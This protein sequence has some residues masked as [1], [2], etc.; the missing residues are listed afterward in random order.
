M[1]TS[2]SARHADQ[3]S[4]VHLSHL[5][6]GVLQLREHLRS[7]L[8]DDSPQTEMIVYTRLY[9]LY[10]DFYLPFFVAKSH[11]PSRS[12]PGA[13]SAPSLGARPAA[14]AEARFI[15]A[16]YTQDVLAACVYLLDPASLPA[17]YIV[18]LT[19][20]AC[21]EAHNEANAS[22]VYISAAQR[23]FCGRVFVYTCWSSAALPL[24]MVLQALYPLLDPGV[25]GTPPATATTLLTPTSPPRERQGPSL[26]ENHI[27][28]DL[29][30]QERFASRKRLLRDT[31]TGLVLT[32]ANGVRALFRVLLLND[33]VTP[34]MTGEAAQLLVQL[35]TSPV[36]TLWQQQQQ[37]QQQLGET[38][39]HRSPF[40]G[41]GEE[42]CAAEV[43]VTHVTTALSV[44]DQ[45]RLLAPQLLALLEEH[46]DATSA[47]SSE[48]CTA[49]RPRFL[50]RL[51]AAR[52]RLP[53]ETLEQ[54][55][56]LATAML[57]NALT[58]LPPRD[59]HDF[60]RS[61]RQFFY[62]NK[63]VLSPGF[64]CLSLRSDTDV[65][66][67]DAIAALLRLRSLIKGVSSG[68][69]S[70]VMAHLLPATAAG[71][72]SIC[73]VLASSGDGDDNAAQFVSPSLP[74]ALRSLFTE[75]LSNPS[76]YDLCARAL[77]N[78]CGKAHAH[79]YLPGNAAQPR[80]RYTRDVCGRERLVTGLQWLLLD[81]AATTPGFVH[82]CVDVMVEAC[83]LELFAAGVENVTVSPALRLT[84]TTSL[85]NAPK[86]E[87]DTSPL[88]ALL[89]RLSLEATPEA[90]FGSRGASLASTLELLGRM[91]GLSGVLHRW[92]LGLVEHLLA[93]SSV[94]AHLGGG[95]TRAER[96]QNLSRLQRCGRNILASLT[97]LS[98]STPRGGTWHSV[99]LTDDAQLSLIAGAR[100]VL[101]AFLER[102]EEHLASCE[103][104][105]QL[106]HG[107]QHRQGEAITAVRA[108]WEQ[109]AEKLRAAL[110]SRV[111]IDV[112]VTL[113][114]LARGVDDVVCEVT[115]PQPLYDTTQRLLRLLVRVLFEA[116]DVGAAVRAV[117]CVTWLGMYRFDSKDSTYMADVM[118]SVLA[119]NH[120]PPWLAASVGYTVT[121]Q[122]AT[123][124]RLCRLRVRVLDILLSLT[125]YDE[126]DR[127]LRNLD[128]SLR[129]KHHASLYDVLVALCCATQ[130]AFVQ[131][132][133][134]H[135]IGTYALAMQP[136]VPVSAVCN[137][138][139]DVFRLSRHEMAKAA[140]AAALGKIVASLCHPS[141]A[142]LLVLSELDIDTLQ[143]LALAMSSYRGRPYVEGNVS[144]TAPAISAA[145]EADLHDEVIRLH[146]RE[147]LALLRRTFVGV[148]GT[149]AD[150]APAAA[151]DLRVLSL[152]VSEL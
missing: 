91:L 92:A 122:A 55:L 21:E 118:W 19:P 25:S 148:G 84:E 72:L 100:Q 12:P 144:V 37:Q 127:T 18:T 69:G 124:S 30:S 68:A 86:T 16:T 73:A 117:H 51:D 76:L 128:D 50:A 39:G 41:A 106:S 40:S 88:I 11:I 95:D 134:L 57:L 108:E 17:T 15:M 82:A 147:M 35:L 104:V 61:Y 102:I 116:D 29:F 60:A 6:E 26:I 9:Q 149:R 54:R 132:A 43:V 94:E 78:A 79:C 87:G 115:D 47:V 152:R 42:E 135:F 27:A 14:S 7:A 48:S 113:A 77:V 133:A 93:A 46:A 71:L 111:A 23:R 120:L 24:H 8:L 38:L 136:R 107:K 75:L 70:G 96:W 145:A 22:S 142:T 65:V 33:R 131:V 90:L 119:E 36:F 141:D 52:L 146:G 59:K 2:S 150:A 103:A 13:G 64:G 45:V 80:L 123:A 28:A 83:H 10:R 4:V 98:T 138:C 125:D 139:R 130:D 34:E 74:A 20:P 129:R 31:L 112:A 89:E 140:C 105:A 66:E 137:L 99:I 85:V 49:A 56:H 101:G 143:T 62:T 67:N 53:A 114:T 121:T 32:R 3:L 81:V 126:D 97:L 63:F 44:E 58:R 109:L 5:H 151:D 110:D 1:D